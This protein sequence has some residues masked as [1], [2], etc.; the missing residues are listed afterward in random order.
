MTRRSFG[1]LLALLGLAAA[2]EPPSDRA[3]EPVWGK[4]PCGH[5]AM[6]LQDRGAAAELVTPSGERVYFDD[7]GCMI[8]WL[9]E[10]KSAPAHAWVRGPGGRGWVEARATLYAPGART[11]MDFGFVAAV[12]GADAI[13]YDEMARRVLG[14]AASRK[15]AP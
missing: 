6:L 9:D 3:L 11:P 4:Q 15:E 1:L 12:D 7:V 14:R 2:C 5:C 10:R 8:S 13:S